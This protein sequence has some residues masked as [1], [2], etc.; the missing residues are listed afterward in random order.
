MKSRSHGACQVAVSLAFSATSGFHSGAMGRLRGHPRDEYLSAGN[1]TRLERIEGHHLTCR[2][3]YLQ[4]KFVGTVEGILSYFLG[5]DTSYGQ[6]SQSPS[7]TKFNNND[8]R[9]IPIM[10]MPINQEVLTAISTLF[11]SCCTNVKITI[12]FK[13]RE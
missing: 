2:G 1:V 10:P 8:V 6:V 11:F 5:L 3:A 9:I 4:A 12:I 7:S 13:K